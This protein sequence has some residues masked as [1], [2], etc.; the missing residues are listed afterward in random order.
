MQVIIAQL[1]TDF[2]ENHSGFEHRH[3]FVETREEADPFVHIQVTTE[4]LVHL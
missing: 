1:R 4:I 2:H 3:A